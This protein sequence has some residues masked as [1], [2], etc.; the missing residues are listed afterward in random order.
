MIACPKRLAL[1]FLLAAAFLSAQEAPP[2]AETS[3]SGTV[4][5]IDKRIFGVLPNYRTAEDNGNYEPLT[6]KQ[7]F[8]IAYKDS[9]DWPV[10]MVSAA[11]ASLYQLEDS[12]PS[13]GQ[14]L[15]GYA[16]R[17][18]TSYADQSIGNIFTE[19]LFPSLLHEDPRYFRHPSGSKKSR[20]LYAASRILITRTDSGANRFNYSELIGNSVATGLSNFYYPESRTFNDNIEKLGVQ[21][22]TDAFS[23]VLKEFWPDIKRKWF[24][25]NETP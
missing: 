22:A 13:F 16:K 21:L 4:P 19:G 2:P 17:Y 10:F 8:R 7:K 3:P 18:A 9:F 14:G 20:V 1:T 15:Q 12:N 5:A 24:K 11:F 25:K 6:A 23:N